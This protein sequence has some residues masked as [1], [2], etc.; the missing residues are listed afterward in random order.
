VGTASSVWKKHPDFVGFDRT[1]AAVVDTPGERLSLDLSSP[2]AREYY[3]C[4][5]LATVQA[6]G[7]PAVYLDYGLLAYGSPN[8]RATRVATSADY[9]DFESSISAGLQSWHGI[10]VANSPGNL[11][12][13]ASFSELGPGVWEDARAVSLSLQEAKI[14]TPHGAMPSHIYCYDKRLFAAMGVA[15]GS[16]PAFRPDNATQFD[17]FVYTLAPFTRVAM[18]LRDAMPVPPR[19]DPPQTDDALKGVEFVALR[20]DWGGVITAIFTGRPGDDKSLPVPSCP[21]TVTIDTSWLCTDGSPL[22]IKELDMR[23]PGPTCGASPHAAPLPSAFRLLPTT[24]TGK[25]GER[26]TWA[27]HCNKPGV[28]GFATMLMIQS[29]RGAS[30]QAFLDIAA[31]NGSS[32]EASAIPRGKTDDST[33]PPLADHLNAQ[34]MSALVHQPAEPARSTVAG[35]LDPAGLPFVPMGFYS[36]E[37]LRD[38]A[39]NIREFRHGPNAVGPVGIFGRAGAAQPTVGCDRDGACEWAL[40]DKW[41]NR[42][43]AVGS[44]VFFSLAVQYSYAKSNSTVALAAIT[45]IVGRVKHHHSI[46][47]WY[48]ADEPDGAITN[49]TLTN[50]NARV[51]GVVYHHLK[52]LD[53]RPACICLDSTAPFLDGTPNRHNFPA[54]LPFAD[55]L[56]ADIYPVDHHW[57]NGLQVAKGIQLLRSKSDAAGFQDKRIMLVAQTFGGMECYPREPTAIEERLMAYLALIHGASGIMAFSHADPLVMDVG[58]GADPHLRYPSSTNLW[59]ESRRLAFE[60]AEFTL[61]LLSDRNAASSPSVQ[62]S[63]SSLHAVSLLEDRANTQDSVVVLVANTANEPM[64]M[65]LTLGGSGVEYSDHAVV[66]FHHRNIS[67]APAASAWSDP[68]GVLLK[69]MVEALGTKAYRIFLTADSGA[70]PPLARVNPANVLLNP[71]FEYSGGSGGE[72]DK[73]IAG[74][75]AFPDGFWTMVGNDTDAAIF[76]DNRDSVDGLRSVRIHTPANHTGLML[77]AFPIEAATY[78]GTPGLQPGQKWTLSVWARAPAV[79][80]GQRAPVLRFGAPYYYFYSWESESGAMTPGGNPCAAPQ[81]YASD[82]TLTDT[83]ARYELAV[84]AQGDTVIKCPSPLNVLKDTYDH[85]CYS[86]RAELQMNISV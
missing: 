61:G 43:D 35:V 47:G 9:I 68:S 57:T 37:P 76:V 73:N 70:H 49:V 78:H 12:A 8:W 72:L 77:V 11:L 17:D 19:L 75:N 29:V 41:L 7:V 26:L 21:G 38:T 16:A 20:T 71:S 4:N 46:V 5:I 83:W 86:A 81:C 10:L 60:A 44:A 58:G 6:M 52:T 69:D 85:R 36:A 32:V 42:S 40:I 45:E 54:F 59:S 55:V 84:I 62:T 64:M 48:I 34:T 31:G 25:I 1:G 15:V 14:F 80:V 53:Q 22:V 66:L 39:T 3:R 63:N 74:G 27:V 2:E 18:A 28:K 65:E 30:G 79:A 24:V 33:I 67:L 51:L 50:A 23:D 13:D 56:W 82:V